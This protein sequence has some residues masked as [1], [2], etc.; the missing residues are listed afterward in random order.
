METRR[1]ELIKKFDQTPP[2]IQNKHA[3]WRLAADIE[4]LKWRQDYLTKSLI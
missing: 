1:A 3:R 2:S 4:Q